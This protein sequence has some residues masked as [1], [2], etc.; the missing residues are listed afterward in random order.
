M[1]PR[2]TISV[3]TYQSPSL[4]GEYHDKSNSHYRVH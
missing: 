4:K 1:N 2:L 3:C